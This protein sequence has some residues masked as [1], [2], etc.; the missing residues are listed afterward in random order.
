MREAGL[1]PEHRPE[2]QSALPMQDPPTPASVQ[3]VGAVGGVGEGGAG[4]GVGGV[5]EGAVG[6]LARQT[7]K[8]GLPPEHTPEQQSTFSLQDA[9]T[10]DLTHCVGDGVGT[11]V[12]D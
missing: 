5:G 10:S 12:G 2:Q 6:P 3:I 1:P 8:L 4:A 11:G 7:R 9:P